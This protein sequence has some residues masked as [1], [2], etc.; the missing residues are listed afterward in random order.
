MVFL[1]LRGCPCHRT[2]IAN[3]R[4]FTAN[5]DESVTLNKE[6]GRVAP[7]RD[8]VVSLN[9]DGPSSGRSLAGFL[10]LSPTDYPITSQSP[11][12]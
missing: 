10:A 4:K 12:V 2:V 9:P 1:G 7:D 8:S 5:Q 11:F 3:S 6:E